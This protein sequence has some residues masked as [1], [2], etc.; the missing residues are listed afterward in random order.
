MPEA[1]S[2]PDASPEHDVAQESMLVS[3]GEDESKAVSS[4]PAH[5]VELLEEFHLG[6]GSLVNKLSTCHGYMEQNSRNAKNVSK[7]A[8]ERLKNEADP[9]PI[10]CKKWKMELEVCT[11]EILNCG[12]EPADRCLARVSKEAQSSN[13]P[14]RFRQLLDFLNGDASQT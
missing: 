7:N 11:L 5:M 13:A 12:L 2:S 6:C 1:S 14:S 4:T 9:V 3:A 10:I 8:A